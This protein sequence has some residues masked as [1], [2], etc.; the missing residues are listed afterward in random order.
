MISLERAVGWAA[1]K[2]LE[3]FSSM[4]KGCKRLLVARGL[5]QMLGIVC[6]DIGS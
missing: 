6:C 4:L 1:N 5:V 3:R 2:I